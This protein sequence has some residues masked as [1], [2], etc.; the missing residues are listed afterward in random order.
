MASRVEG[1]RALRWPSWSESG[2]AVLGAYALLIPAGGYL[3]VLRFWRLGT[4]SVTPDKALLLILV[5]AVALRRAAGL[6]L[7]GGRSAPAAAPV[8]RSFLPFLAFSLVVT[9]LGEPSL[10]AG[11]LEFLLLSLGVLYLWTIAVAVSQE[12][13]RLLVT[14]LLAA[15]TATSLLAI[16]Q[17]TAGLTYLGLA[18]TGEGPGVF[19]ATILGNPVVLGSVLAGLIPLTFHRLVTSRR[20]WSLVAYALA[21]LIQLQGLVLT[22]SRSAWLAATA[23]ATAYLAL[24]VFRR[25]SGA[26]RKAALA[27]VLALAVLVAGMVAVPHLTAGLAPQGRASGERGYLQAIAERFSRRQTLD[28]VSFTHR[29]S[30]YRLV[31]EIL[32]TDHLLTGNGLGSAKRILPARGVLVDTPDNFFLTLLLETGVIGLVLFVGAWSAVLWPAVRVGLDR[33]RTPGASG[34]SDLEGL[35]CGMLAMLVTSLFF[36]LWLLS[37]SMYVFN[38]LAGLAAVLAAGPHPA[39]PGGSGWRP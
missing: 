5:A 13:V 38:A 37:S 26:L 18:A 8:V 30:M 17:V 29:A 23:G 31:P 1:V 25:G 4:V 12:G 7:R 3:P 27:G 20:W 2:V 6:V 33:G 24:L 34:G 9:A 15:G 35:L 28:S 32:G 14:V 16:L 22:Y 19:R 10:P 39:A 11:L 36:D 21:L